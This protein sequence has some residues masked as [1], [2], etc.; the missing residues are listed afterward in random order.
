MGCGVCT[1]TCSTGALRLERVEREK[2][3]KTSRAL[4]KTVAI[5]N[6]K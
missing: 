4:Y 6:R 5:E 2:P 3:F 1:L